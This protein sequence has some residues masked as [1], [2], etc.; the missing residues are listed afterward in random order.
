M[1]PVSDACYDVIVAGAGPAGATT[2]YELARRGFR[3]LL[4]DKERLPRYKVCA[5]G[6]TLKTTQLLDFDLSPAYEEEISRGTCTY[7]GGSP[8]TI[9]FGEPVGWTVMRDK[10][11]Q[12]IVRQAQRAGAEVLDS[13]RVTGVEFLSGG[14]SVFTSR[15]RYSCS[16]LVGADGA[17][18]VV[19]RQAGLMRRRNLAAA[20]EAEVPTSGEPL[21][22]RRGSIQFDFGCVP[23]GYGWVFPKKALLSVG[24]GTFWGKAANLKAFLSRWLETL[25]LPSDPREV[26]MRGHLVPL[27]G[28]SRVLHGPRVLLTGDAAGLAEPMTGEGIYYAVRSARIAAEVVYQALQNDLQD[29]STYTERINSEI[30]RD[31]KYAKRLAALLYRFPRLCFHFFVRSPR[32]QRGVTDALCGRSS[33][34]ELDHELRA[35]SLKILISGMWRTQRLPT[36][37][38]AQQDAIPKH[39]D[40]M[41][42]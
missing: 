41:E 5:G 9:D 39:G 21:D 7:R 6:V 35:A 37:S 17:N 20:V 33:F 1:E 30:A 42:R 29:L 19:A 34:E 25:G 24:V 22:S 2:A 3:V 4:L 16:I 40:P 27:G 15:G 31:L 28:V 26:R 10:F 38:K 23:R 18:G 14:V 13:E 8:I 32:V 12:L 36:T 11:D